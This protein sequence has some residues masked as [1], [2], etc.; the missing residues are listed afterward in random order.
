MTFKIL[1]VRDEGT[2][3]PVM[4]IRMYA[5]TDIQRYYMIE[6]CS[7]PANGSGIVVMM[8]DNQTATVDPY[9]W[10]LLGLGRRTMR[11]AHDYIE[12]HFD[13]LQDGDVVD[14]QF[15]LG[16][17]KVKKISERLK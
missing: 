17:T 6:R 12:T 3:I 7:Y 16:E 9:E 11:T 13:E 5:L 10:P 4:A 14:V 8:L 2:H 15:L 1:E